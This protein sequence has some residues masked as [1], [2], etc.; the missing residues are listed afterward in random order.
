[1]ITGREKIW[2]ICALFYSVLNIAIPFFVLKDMG[3]LAGAFLFWN[4]LTGAVLLAGIW[5]TAGWKEPAISREPM[6]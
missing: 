1:M 4:I 2:L 6:K 3:S 5:I